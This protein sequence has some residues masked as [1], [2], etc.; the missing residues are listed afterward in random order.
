MMSIM[1]FSRSS[2]SMWRPTQG[3]AGQQPAAPDWLNTG[4]CH[5]CSFGHLFSFRLLW[6]YRRQP[7]SRVRWPV[8]EAHGSWKRVQLN[9]QTKN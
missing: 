4:P 8:R 5:V 1:S 2:A 9:S 7:V 6:C 3:K